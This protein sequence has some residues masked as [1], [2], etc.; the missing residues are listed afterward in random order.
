MLNSILSLERDINNMPLG[1]G[2]ACLQA[3]SLW[4]SR[5]KGAA[6]VKMSHLCLA[7]G[8]PTCWL[9]PP[10]PQRTVGSSGICLF[11]NKHLLEAWTIVTTFELLSV[12][13][14]SFPSLHPSYSATR[15]IY[16][17]H[18]SDH[19]TSLLKNHQCFPISQRIMS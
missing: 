7:R 16:L 9:L 1:M 6:G 3:L 13:G 14:V 4:G 10:G 17:K 15:A 2:L 12:L 8:T 5:H 18:K 11:N 19:V